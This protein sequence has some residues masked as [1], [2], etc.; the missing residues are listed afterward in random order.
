M[1]YVISTILDEWSIQ[2]LKQDCF[3]DTKVMGAV[4]VM[5]GMLGLLW[6]LLNRI[7]GPARP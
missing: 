1:Y 4:A 6:V 3:S 2:T 7:N 5:K